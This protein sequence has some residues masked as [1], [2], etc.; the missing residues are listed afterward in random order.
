MVDGKIYTSKAELRR[1]YKRA[2]YVEKDK[3][4]RVTPDNPY[5]SREYREKLE[6]DTAR[7]FTPCG[8]AWPL[9]PNLIE[10]DANY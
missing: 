7:A 2:G 9:C 3:G 6:E 5:E 10:N 1:H 4:Y 8:M